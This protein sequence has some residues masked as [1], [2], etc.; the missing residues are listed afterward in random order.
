M[1]VSNVPSTTHTHTRTD[2]EKRGEVVD[3]REDNKLSDQGVLEL[4]VS[5]V[6]FALGENCG[7]FFVALIDRHYQHS[8]Q[9]RHDVLSNRT[10]G[11]PRFLH[12]DFGGEHSHQYAEDTKYGGGDDTAGLGTELGCELGGGSAV[13]PPM[14]SPPLTHRKAEDRRRVSAGWDGVWTE[15]VETEAGSDPLPPLQPP[16]RPYLPPPLF[17]RMASCACAGER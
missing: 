10:P 8:V 7:Q 1:A 16:P 17:R 6:I 4:K 11:R 14:P 13:A 3:E 2:V 9:R 5:P 12:D 15:G